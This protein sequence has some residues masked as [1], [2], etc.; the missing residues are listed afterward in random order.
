MIAALLLAQALSPQQVI[1]Y[2][3][4]TTPQ[5]ERTMYA[6]M[7]P[8]PG[9]V[10]VLPGLQLGNAGDLS[11]RLALGQAGQP[12]GQVVYVYA[13]DWV[14]GSGYLLQ[15]SYQRVPQYGVGGLWIQRDSQYNWAVRHLTRVLQ[16]GGMPDSNP[17]AYPDSYPYT[18]SNTYPATY[19][20]PNTNTYTFSYTY[21]YPYT[22]PVR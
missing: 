15:G 5:L 9:L 2:L 12:L 3:V 1:A 6:Q 19:T 8:H 7:V 21:P 11:Q 4:T 18:Y 20:D 14:Q 17:Y 10:P 16:T 22:Y 13:T